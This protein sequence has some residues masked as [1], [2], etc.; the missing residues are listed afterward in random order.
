MEFALKS[1][2]YTNRKVGKAGKAGSVEAN[3]DGYASDLA[4][5]FS[6]TTSPA[7]EQAVNFYLAEPPRKQ[8]EVNGKLEWIDAPYPDSDPLLLTLIRYI[9]RVRN[10]FFHGGKLYIHEPSNPNRDPQLIAHAM[11]ILEAVLQRSECH[12]EA[13]YQA[14]LASGG[15]V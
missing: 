1:A 8:D 3:W 9:R 15:K 13:V 14:Y 11:V 10:N 12:C 7:L 6:R 5:Y 4:D 2:G